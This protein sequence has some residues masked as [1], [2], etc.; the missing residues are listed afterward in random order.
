MKYNR[1]NKHPCVC[2]AQIAEFL[3]NFQLMCYYGNE[4]GATAH[5][6]V[7]LPD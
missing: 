4:K 6:V 1:E 3:A 2:P 5:K 7:N